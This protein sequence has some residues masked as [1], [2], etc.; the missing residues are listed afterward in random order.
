ML[1]IIGKKTDRDRQAEEEI[2]K[3]QEEEEKN[4]GVS[5]D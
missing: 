1:K 3:K 2:K 4:G 5:G